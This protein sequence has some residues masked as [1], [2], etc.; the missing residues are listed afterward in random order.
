MS[1]F[2]FFLSLA[3][4]LKKVYINSMVREKSPLKREMRAFKFWYRIY[5]FY[6]YM[7]PL[8]K[9]RNESS[10]F[11]FI[12]GWASFPDG[13]PTATSASVAKSSATASRLAKGAAT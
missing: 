7:Y 4:A 5:I 13:P 10:H 11:F 8:T 2:F 9:L 12:L 3:S 6:V 1:L